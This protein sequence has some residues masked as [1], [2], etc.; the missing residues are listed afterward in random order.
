MKK[1]SSD[2]SSK[3]DRKT[4]ERNRRIHMKALCFKLAS[5]IPPHYLKHTKEMISQQDQLDIAASYIKTLREKLENLKGKK[6]EAMK[7]KEINSNLGMESMLMASNLPLLELRDLG[8]SIEVMLIS[9]LNR[10]FM[11]YEVISVLEEEGAEVVSASFSTVGD[12]IFHTVHAQVKISRV[13]VETTR[14]Y[15]RLHDLIAPLKSWE[16]F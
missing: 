13:G 8:S 7:L 10:N 3:V 14:V 15:Q 12:K 4:I 2:S 6:E 5:L 16:Y 9:G 1:A 11:L